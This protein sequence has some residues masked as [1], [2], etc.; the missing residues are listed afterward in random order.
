[1]KD[2]QKKNIV[3]HVYHAI[4]NIS[5]VAMTLWLLLFVIQ[6]EL[7]MH[8]V[9][10]FCVKKVSDKLE[11]SELVKLCEILNPHNKPGRLTIITRMGA[12]NTRVKL[13]HMIRA[14]R[15]AGLIVTWVSDPMHGNTISAPCGLK[16][17][18]FDAIR[19]RTEGMFRL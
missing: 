5:T 14:V 6:N 9:N 16:T 18:S 15:Q 11:P 12:E 17:R 8:I 7:S 19:V 13:P 3:Y 4:A 10:F 2:R 1:M